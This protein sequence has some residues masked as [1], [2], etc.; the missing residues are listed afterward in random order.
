MKNFSQH[1]SKKLVVVIY[2]ATVFLLFTQNIAA[3]SWDYLIWQNRSKNSDP[4]YRFI[5][6]GKAGFIN[7]SGKIVIQPTLWAS[8]N[9]QDGVI[10]GLLETNYQKYIDLKTGNKVSSDYYHQNISIFDGLSVKRFENKFGFTD[11][12]GKTII[13][14]KF[15]YAKDFSEGLAPVVLEGPCYYYNSESPCPGADT[16][17]VGTNSQPNTACQFNF[18]NIEGKLIS[19]RNFLDV[20]EF[21][22]NLAPVKTSEGW[23]YMNKNGRIIIAPQFEEA[24]PFSE[25]LALVKH[26]NLYGY[27]NVAGTFVIEPQFKSAESFSSGLAPV[28]EYGDETVSNKFYYINKNGKPATSDKFLLASRYF[29]GL[30][31]VLVTESLKV[32]KKDDKELEIRKQI[33]SYIDAK[34]T[35][36][37]TYTV[38]N[39]N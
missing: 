19:D 25:G 18:I 26:R 3:C 29:K 33:Y 8:G 23:G 17:P 35:K 22:E 7:Q 27:I 14:P 32:N 13:E 9:Y 6:N 2:V 38:E 20:K 16:F 1:A 11:R 31:H 12:R 15:V 37:F 4:Y 39:E 21:S 24:N 28:G 30:A 10:N 34:G 36:I 5:K